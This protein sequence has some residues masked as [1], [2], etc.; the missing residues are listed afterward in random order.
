MGLGDTLA[1]FPIGGGWDLWFYANFPNLFRHLPEPTR[2]RIISTALGAAPGWF[3]T[4][5]VPGRVPIFPGLQ[6]L[7]TEVVKGRVDLT[8][9]AL[10]GRRTTLTADHV[11]AATGYRADVSK[12]PFL[13][14]ALK[15]GIR[16]S[17]GPPVLSAD[18]ESSE[19]GL[20]FVGASSA[21]TFGPVA[22][23]VAGAGFTVRK[24]SHR[25]AVAHAPSRN[26]RT[27]PTEGRYI[28]WNGKG[29]T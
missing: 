19:P 3:M 24:L 4:D 18:F 29:L 28:K 10:D 12:L 9:K 22:R 16:T 27:E 20:Y 7:G 17:G 8:A 23:F 11:V 6:I 25:L 1:G 21:A 15:N 5:R 14:R 2:K 13:D 26:P